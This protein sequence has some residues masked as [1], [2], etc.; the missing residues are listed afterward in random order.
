MKNR[1]SFQFTRPVRGATIVFDSPRKGMLFQFTRP[2]WGA[3][4]NFLSYDVTRVPFQFTRPRGAT[5]AFPRNARALQVSIH[6]PS[7]CP[8]ASYTGF[9]FTRPVWGA[10]SALKDI[11]DTVRVSIHAPR[12]GSDEKRIIAPNSTTTF[13]FTR[14]VRGATKIQI[15]HNSPRL[16]QLTRPVWGAT[17]TRWRNRPR[18]TV[19]IHPTPI[20][21]KM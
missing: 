20:L 8:F 15:K 1:L 18:T 4:A 2:M 5:G 7:L 19:S 17:P 14:P 13:Q 9:Q 11:S 3:T 10:T 12:A 6:A 16:F 21:K